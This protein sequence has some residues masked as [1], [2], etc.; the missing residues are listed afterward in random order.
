MSQLKEIY[1]KLKPCPKPEKPVLLSS[2]KRRAL[3]V[4]LYYG[5]A[6]GFC[7]FCDHPVELNTTY[8]DLFKHCHLVHIIPR[9]KG[10]DTEENC[11]IGC[12]DC[13]MLGENGHL[14]WRSDKRRLKD[15]KA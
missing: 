13:H 15:A 2:A 7:E 10:G 1:D 12:Y 9:K 11:K 14:A 3:K 5:R 6:R 4:K 8:F